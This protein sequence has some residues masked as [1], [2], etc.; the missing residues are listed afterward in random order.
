MIKS[1]AAAA[2]FAVGLSGIAFA[3]EAAPAAA[4]PAPMMHHKTMAKT[5]MCYHTVNGVKHWH[6][7]HAAAMPK[8]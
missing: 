5:P 6:H 7:C 1:L 4:A 2:I 3:Q 8:S